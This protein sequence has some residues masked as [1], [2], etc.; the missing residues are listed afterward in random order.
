MVDNSSFL[1]FREDVGVWLQ[2]LSRAHSEIT[3]GQGYHE[4]RGAS[5]HYSVDLAYCL[6]DLSEH[7]VMQNVSA[8]HR[9]EI[10]RDERKFSHLTLDKG[11][12]RERRLLQTI[13]KDFESG[14]GNIE[15]ND[16]EPSLCQGYR[17]PA[18]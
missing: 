6:F 13:S 2:P 14:F 7:A 3:L 5:F 15:T 17:V 12:V 16:M 4:R 10:V 8:D 1:T 9:V 18:C 11:H